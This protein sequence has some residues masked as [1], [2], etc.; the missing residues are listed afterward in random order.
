MQDLDSEQLTVVTGGTRKLDAQTELALT[1]LASDIK[2]L[3]HNNT[4]NQ[5]STLTM[6]LMAA[7]VSKQRG[8]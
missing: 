3:G 7:L 5:N 8:G 4:Q 1:K 6:L 2:D